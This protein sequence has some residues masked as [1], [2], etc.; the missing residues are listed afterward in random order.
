MSHKRFLII[1]PY[2]IGDVLFTM[3]MIKNIKA[4]VSDAFIGFISNRRTAPLLE[5]LPEVNKVTI[6]DRDEFKAVSDRSKIEFLKLLKK[7]KS[8]LHDQRYDILFDLSMTWYAS[9]YGKLVGIQERVGLNYKNRSPF[10]TKKIFVNGYEGRHTAEYYLDLVR[11]M[12]WDIKPY[13]MQVTIPSRDELWAQEFIKKNSLLSDKLLVVFPG[14]G[15]SWGQDANFKRW[16]VE[17]YAQLIQKIIGD[18][19]VSIILMGSLR[20]ESLCKEIQ[21]LVKWP[22]FNACGTT[23]LVQTMAILSKSRLVVV[24]DGGP[25]H[26][27]VAAGTKTVSIFGPVDENVYGPYANTNSQHR[28]VTQR[29][30]CRP[31]Y[32]HFR[33]AAC[34]HISC[35]KD[36][37]VEQVF[38]AV[39]NSLT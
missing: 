37:E 19:N 17:K 6:Y 25:L 32:R 33:R 14:G 28:V 20:E 24:S 22:L 13:S 34:E 29:I 11:T 7:T 8:E 23:S 10:L 27:A 38:V 36:I 35:I 26:M 12:G 4:N 31:C 21:N 18:F 3:P 30:A 2:G 16:P 39:K 15:E 9:F 5:S 1:N